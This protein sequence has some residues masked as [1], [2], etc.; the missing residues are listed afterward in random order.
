VKCISSFFI[1]PAPKSDFI[2]SFSKQAPLSPRQRFP[3]A[4]MA[5][6]T[7]LNEE[8]RTDY[9]CNIITFVSGDNNIFLSIQTMT[10]FVNSISFGRLLSSSLISTVV[11][12]G[13]GNGPCLAILPIDC[14]AKKLYFNPFSIVHYVNTC[15]KYQIVTASG[16]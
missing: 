15:S 2:T 8:M 4:T 5:F 12:S 9:R 10:C 16:Y 3:N 1:D 14:I 11:P 7:N 6:S 13:N